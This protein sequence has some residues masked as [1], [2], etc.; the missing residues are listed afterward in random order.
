MR[1]AVPFSMQNA[2]KKR[3]I[4]VLSC[5]QLSFKM[6]KATG[7]YFGQLHKIQFRIRKKDL[8]NVNINK[9]QIIPFCRIPQI[10]YLCR[11]KDAIEP[12]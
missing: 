4:V 3:K 2:H 6:K 9:I 7:G 12:I 8:K 11:K 10:D 5:P 1:M